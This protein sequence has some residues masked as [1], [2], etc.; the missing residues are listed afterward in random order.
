MGTKEQQALRR[1]RKSTEH[2]QN[3]VVCQAGARAC[4][5]LENPVR[6]HAMM[7]TGKCPERIPMA[8]VA[9]ECFL[10]QTYP[11]RRL[12]IVNHG[13]EPLRVQVRQNP[14]DR[15]VG[16]DEVMVTRRELPTL[17]DLRNRALDL[18]LSGLVCTWDDDDW[19][20]DDYMATM[21]SAYRLGCIV[22]MRRQLRHDLEANTSFIKQATDGHCG[23]VL[24][25]AGTRYRYPS[26]D[27]HEDSVF[28]EQFGVRR[29]L[30]VNDP[31]IYVRIFHGHNTWHR[32]H[33][34]G[35]LSAKTNV[36]VISKAQMALVARVR[37]L[38]GYEDM[39]GTETCDN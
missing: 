7:I 8:R 17:G 3:E 9:A 26:L 4:K 28:A 29:I 2:K 23:Q 15:Y 37:R 1:P 11:D 27:R 31:A 32:Q 10:R 24:Y 30:L 21:V 19:M 12:L 20:A 6:V 35:V 22:L 13:D 36:H 39:A 5:P 38:Y 34:M 14:G 18:C 33:V 25:A 16:C